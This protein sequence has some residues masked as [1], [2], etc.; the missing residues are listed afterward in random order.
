MQSGS[1]NFADGIAETNVTIISLDTNRAAAF[2]SVQP[3]GGQNTG[4]SPSTGSVLGVGSATLAM[5]SGHASDAGSQQHFGP[6]GCRLVRGRIWAE[7]LA[8]A[9]V[10]GSAISADTTTNIYTSLTGPIYT[11]IQNGN[12]GAGTIILK[13]PAGFIFDTNAPPPSVLI[14]RVGGGADS[15][16]I[17][18]VASGTLWR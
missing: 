1:V 6:G 14:T 17:N 12:V 16:N 3:A 13:A 4:R 7:L 15:L 10:G 2:A 9:R 5:T 8:H 18:G 11:E